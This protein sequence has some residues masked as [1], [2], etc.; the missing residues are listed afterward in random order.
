MTQKNVLKYSICSLYD[1]AA[2]SK[3]SSFA[4]FSVAS[5]P[6]SAAQGRVLRT[7]LPRNSVKRRCK[8]KRFESFGHLKRRET[9][10]AEQWGIRPRLYLLICQNLTSISES[11]L[12]ACCERTP[13]FDFFCRK[14]LCPSLS[15]SNHVF[16]LRIWILSKNDTEKRSKMLNP[17]PL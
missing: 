10:F 11:A 8:F 3:N 1:E 17:W 16:T 4:R 13:F 6:S 14:N 9:R 5:L 2:N 12:K 15:V 7:P